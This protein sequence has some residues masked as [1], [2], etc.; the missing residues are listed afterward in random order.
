VVFA[1]LLLAAIA[2]YVTKGWE[3][4]SYALLAAAVVAL[5]ITL[6]RRSPR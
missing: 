3:P 1:A 4:V 2:V 6:T 5:V